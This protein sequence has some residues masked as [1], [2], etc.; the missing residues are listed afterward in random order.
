MND[1]LTS[2]V[3]STPING[4]EALSSIEY[5]MMKVDQ[6]RAF[7]IVIWHLREHLRGSC[8]PPLRMIIHGEGGTGK[9]RVIQCITKKFEEM[10]AKHLLEKAAYTG[11]A[12]SLIDGRTTHSV[13]SIG[14]RGQQVVQRSESEAH[15][16]L[17]VIRIFHH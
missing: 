9:T 13:G 11:I 10:G 5:A 15:Q 6:Q 16:I 12:A 17:E 2:A 7:D 1:P 4:E 14:I 8:P 3:T